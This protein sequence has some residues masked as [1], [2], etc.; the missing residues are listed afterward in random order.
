MST[1]SAGGLC[2]GVPH[3]PE[4][5]DRRSELLTRPG[6]LH[7]PA[8]LRARQRPPRREA[9]QRGLKYQ[10]CEGFSA[11]VVRWGG[12]YSGTVK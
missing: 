4:G 9:P 2:R 3:G 1:R 12:Y 8:P 5:T 7:N 10:L 11:A 6:V